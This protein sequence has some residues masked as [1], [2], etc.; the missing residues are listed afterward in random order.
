MANNP[1]SDRIEDTFNGDNSFSYGNE[2][3]K[4][5]PLIG[6]KFSVAKKTKE[7]KISI[8]KRWTTS[9]KKIEIPVSYEE[10]YVDGKKI[11]SHNKNETLKLFSRGISKI[12]NTFS[13]AK[14]TEYEENPAD[15]LKVR[16]YDKDNDILNEKQN[17]DA[18]NTIPLS[19]NAKNSKIESIVTIWG[20]EI[21]INKRMVKL[22]EFVVKKH[23]I[24][25]T[26]QI[27]VELTSEKLSIYQP[28]SHKEEIT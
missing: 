10:I 14:N 3:V 8:E 19:Y 26:K 28:D 7:G 23:E 25:E 12:K 15:T 17:N 27:D 21:V 4:K 6:E 22:G 16:H 5:I 18:G 13:N 2:I 11:E 24:T 20:E 9:T 1:D